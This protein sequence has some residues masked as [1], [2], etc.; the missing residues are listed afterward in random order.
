[1]QSV[2]LTEILE[3]HVNVQNVLQPENVFVAVMEEHTS[4][5]VNLESN[6][7][8]RKQILELFIKANAVSSLNAKL[9]SSCK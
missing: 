5:N 8:Q 9:I 4:M 7:V 1:M 2:W 6:L 3:L